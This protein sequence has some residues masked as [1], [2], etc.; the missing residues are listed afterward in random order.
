[1]RPHARVAAAHTA[2]G[3]R[4]AADAR[5]AVVRAMLAALLAAAMVFVLA[6]C[7]VAGENEPLTLDSLHYDV[8]IQSNG[9]LMVTETWNVNLERREDTDGNDRPW[10]QLF[11]TFKA[12]PGVYDGITDVN[13]R[14]AERRSY[15]QI[16]LADPENVPEDQ[17]E[18]LAG[19]YYLT[20]TDADTTEL[21]WNIPPTNSGSETYYVSYRVKNAITGLAD[22]NAEFNWQF[23]DT[24][25]GIYAKQVTGLISVP[26]STRR[27]QSATLTRDDVRAWLHFEHSPSELT[28]D[29]NGDVYFKAE[30]LPAQVQL[31]VH[32]TFPAQF[33]PNAKRHSA[34]TASTIAAGEQRMADE[35]QAKVEAKN[36]AVIALCVV[37]LL[38]ILGMLAWTA[39]SIR[40]SR[41]L[42]RYRGDMT[43]W[44]DDPG[45]PP[46]VAAKIIGL[47]DSSVAVDRNGMAATMLSLAHKRWVGL[48][49]SPPGPRGTQDVVITL[50]DP[51]RS[52]A[53]QL[54]RSEQALLNVLRRA[55]AGYG[56]RPFTMTELHEAGKLDYSAFDGLFDA[57]RD[58]VSMECGAGHL[59]VGTSRYTVL[60]C[61]VTI[62]IGMLS[63][64]GFVALGWQLLAFIVIGAAI[65][66][67][68]T[69]MAKAKSEILT[70]EG[71]LV[72]GRLEGLKRYMLDFS[73]F[74]K[75]GVPDLAMWDFYLVY[76]AAFG[77]SDQVVRQLRELYPQ[78]ND[79]A[80]MDG[81]WDSSPVMYSTFHHHAPTGMGSSAPTGITDLGSMIGSNFSD[82]QSAV[83]SLSNPSSYGGGGGGGG[84][85]GGSSGGGG[86]GGMGGR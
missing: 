82:I 13:V 40:T 8:S 80:F 44:R 67:C 27:E 50:R 77:I 49:M 60:P 70:P 32:A 55:S 17:Y 68:V 63:M 85:F 57:Y 47:G 71:N 39:W 9:D 1:M 21:G 35:W 14:D 28:I 48:T 58:A 42:A 3:I 6:S 36:H 73:D 86:G 61:A 16:D 76:A 12:R 54:S 64:L 19:T 41:R 22:G 11:R 15:E 20:K 25:N 26:D 59:S 53:S 51:R 69:V 33:A 5:P 78:L 2:A 52:H 24:T 65:V 30:P 23:L 7:G 46:A 34:K 45:V 37:S 43:Y 56:G 62:G 66:L 84:G 29:D 31:E 83:S 38:L 74:S 10:H 81:T 18:E 72:A 4:R 79:P 75:R